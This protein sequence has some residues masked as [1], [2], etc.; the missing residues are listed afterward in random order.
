MLTLSNSQKRLLVLHCYK[1]GQNQLQS[2]QELYQAWGIQAPSMPSIYRLFQQFSAGNFELEDQ[3]REGRPNTAITK[4]TINAVAQIVNE[5]PTVSCEEI[6]QV[7]SISKMSAY[8]ILTRELNLSKLNVSWVPHM[9]TDKQKSARLDFCHNFLSRFKESNS[10]SLYNVV[11]GDETYIYFYDPPDNKSAQQWHPKGAPPPK[12]VQR[13]LFTRKVLVT[14][15]FSIKGIIYTEVLDEKSTVTA[16]WYTNVCLNNLLK[17][18]QNKWPKSYQSRIILHHDNAKPH[19]AKETK[20]FLEENNIK[21]LSHPPYSPDLAPC[22]FWLFKTIK[23]QL[24][25]QIYAMKDELLLA[26]DSALNSLSKGDFKHCFKMWFR[27][28]EKVIKSNGN[29]S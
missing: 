14:I 17:T 10:N 24:K 8:H 20:T 7:L 12:R 11:T 9:L 21:L 16:N 25:G 4:E 1:K 3:P 19:T 18:I 27:Q 13:S 23:P 2:Y 5:N 6:G 22:D 15:F 28:C 29:Y 26:L